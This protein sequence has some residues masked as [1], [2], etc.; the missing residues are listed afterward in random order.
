MKTGKKFAWDLVDSP[1][2]RTALRKLHPFYRGVVRR[3]YPGT[4]DYHKAVLMRYEAIIEDGW[5]QPAKVSVR[6]MTRETDTS[7]IILGFFHRTKLRA[8]ITLTKLETGFEVWLLITMGAFEKTKTGKR[9][10][11][12]LLDTAEI[13]C[14]GMKLGGL[15]GR[16][17]RQA[18][19]GG[20]P[21]GFTKVHPEAATDPS[22]SELSRTLKKQ[23]APG[24]AQAACMYNE[25]DYLFI[26]KPC[27]HTQPK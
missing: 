25:G 12:I 1:Q 4:E 27:Q 8:T 26:V 3:V 15:A 2:W 19:A 13:L 22:L 23:A 5:A 9:A 18:E 20:C 11:G 14:R 6:Q 10:M 7:D 16:I 24:T 21:E 17:P